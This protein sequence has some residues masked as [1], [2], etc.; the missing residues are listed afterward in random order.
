MNILALD[1]SKRSTGWAYYGQGGNTAQHGVWTRLG[2]EYTSRGGLFYNL[3]KTLLE[4]RQVMP[5]DMIYA[6]QPV[7]LIP[8][9]VATTA[10]NVWIAVGM[11]ATVELFAHSF[12][13]PLN[14][15][16]QARWRREFLGRMPRAVKSSQLK[17]Y[18]MERARQLGFR[19]Q[20]HDDAEA[21]GILTYALQIERQPC[22]WVADE[23]LR[24]ALGAAR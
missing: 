14:W 4:H 16:H 8:N 21:I 5:F 9:S 18:A 12:G 20:R 6:E 23:V 24:Q 10:E 1:L 22:P 15:I 13:V 17:D 11:A 7:N 19:P 3:Y 2:S